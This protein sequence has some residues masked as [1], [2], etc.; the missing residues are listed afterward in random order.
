[1]WENFV[2]YSEFESLAL[3]KDIQRVPIQSK[4]MLEGYIT[5]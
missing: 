5:G 1:M 4:W 3:L 2:I